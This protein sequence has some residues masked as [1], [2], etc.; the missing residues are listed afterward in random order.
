LYLEL[1]DK[2][3]IDER[4]KRVLE[5]CRYENLSFIF[6]FGRHMHKMGDH[7]FGKKQT[8]CTDGHIERVIREFKRMH[9]HFLKDHI[10]DSREL[11]EELGTMNKIFSSMMFIQV[12]YIQDKYV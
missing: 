6:D 4:R 7:I 8:T 5:K 1:V 12:F 10:S 2:K 11:K 3:Q 9:V